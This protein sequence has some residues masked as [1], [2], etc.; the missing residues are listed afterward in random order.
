LA[1]PSVEEG[2][3][4]CPTVAASE[5]A[6]TTHDMHTRITR[7]Q[8]QK[9]TLS[10]VQEISLI[11]PDCGQEIWGPRASSPAG[12]GC[13]CWW[14]SAGVRAEEGAEGR[15]KLCRRTRVRVT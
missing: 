6:T 4:C 12:C 1:A 11:S 13:G 9:V 10:Q 7:R 14:L 2:R 8:P 5:A 3:R 15:A